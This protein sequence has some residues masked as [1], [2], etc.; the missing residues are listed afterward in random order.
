MNL[1]YVRRPRG[2]DEPKTLT[3]V[4]ST[5]LTNVRH[6]GPRR[7]WCH[8]KDFFKKKSILSASLVGEPTK[9][10]HNIQYTNN[11]KHI[12]NIQQ[13]N[14]SNITSIDQTLPRHINIQ[15]LQ[16]LGCNARHSAELLCST[17]PPL[18]LSTVWANSSPSEA[19]CC[20][21]EISKT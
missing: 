10:V 12:Y 5:W 17:P 8:I 3:F 2:T 13:S 9:Q 16:V 1:T 7:P 11:S 20:V 18:V 4:G 15:T 14:M 6:V 19:S 21:S